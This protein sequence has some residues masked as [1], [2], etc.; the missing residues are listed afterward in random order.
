MIQALYTIGSAVPS[1]QWHVWMHVVLAVS[2]CLMVNQQP[3]SVSIL[4]TDRRAFPVILELILK[5]LNQLVFSTMFL[6]DKTL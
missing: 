4:S 6:T 5:E 1:F 3:V 2:I